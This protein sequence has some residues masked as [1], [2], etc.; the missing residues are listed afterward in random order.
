MKTF[1]KKLKNFLRKCWYIPVILVFCIL[2]LITEFLGKGSSTEKLIELFE[3]AKEKYKGER[4]VVERNQEL[5]E[6]EKQKV[7]EE[8]DSRIAEVEERIEKKKEEIDK[9]HE[10][11]VE[12]GDLDTE[13]LKGADAFG[14][15]VE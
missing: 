7:E 6:K 3:R 11:R 12:D 1:F 4:E 2:I 10:K 5:K 8:F 15:E 13:V 14:F 9:L